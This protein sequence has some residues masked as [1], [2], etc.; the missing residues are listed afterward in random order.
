MITLEKLSA[1]DQRVVE[2][3][4]IIEDLNAAMR[5]LSYPGRKNAVANAADADFGT[6]AVAT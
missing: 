4:S 2:A 3:R 6:S 1:R 5:W